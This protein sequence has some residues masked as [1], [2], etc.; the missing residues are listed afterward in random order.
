MKNIKIIIIFTVFVTIGL[1]LIGCNKDITE[2][3]PKW[4]QNL[5]LNFNGYEYKVSQETTNDIDNYIGVVS[6]RGSN[7]NTY[8]LY[9]IKNIKDYTKIAVKTQDGYL[10]AIKGNPVQTEY[11]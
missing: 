6:Y 9:S 8:K 10:I 7:S 4:S 2:Q 3:S 11:K 1:I 5:N